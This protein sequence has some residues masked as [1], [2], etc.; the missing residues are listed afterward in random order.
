LPNRRVMNTRAIM[1]NFTFH[2]PVGIDNVIQMV[3]F[4]KP[5]IKKKDAPDPAKVEENPKTRE[6]VYAVMP[7]RAFRDSRINKS[8]AI[9]VLGCICS[10]TNKAGITWVSNTRIG[11]YLGV[12]KQA[13]RKQILRLIECGYVKVVSAS[14][15]YSS[16]TY[17]VIFDESIDAETAIANLP[18]KDREGMT[19]QEEE[20]KDVWDKKREVAKTHLKKAHEAL[21]A[22]R[23]ASKDE[24]LSTDS[25]ND[26]LT[27][28]VNDL[29]RTLTSEVN[30][31]SPLEVNPRSLPEVNQSSNRSLHIRYKSEVLKNGFN[32]KNDNQVDLTTLIESGI[33]EDHVAGMV[34]FFS[35]EWRRNGEDAPGPAWLLRFTP[36]EIREFGAMA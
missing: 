1:D 17:Q 15:G 34:R 11:G 22:K 2:Q 25:T 5:A 33:D 26:T 19:T 13:I 32:V 35:D 29:P 10:H 28:E 8:A 14:H 9:S 36:D 12:S 4:N 23:Q 21:K 3:D 31:G 27:S 16:N 6:T 24:K 20:M 30:L 18:A 7:A